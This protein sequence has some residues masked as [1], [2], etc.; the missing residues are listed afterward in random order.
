MEPKLSLPHSQQ[1][2]QDPIL[3]QTNPVHA[4]NPTSRRS[5]L[6]LS[7][8]LGLDLP[9]G[10]YPSGFPTKTPDAYLFSH[11]TC[12][13]PRQ[14]HSSWFDHTNNI[15]SGQLSSSSS[16]SSKTSVLVISILY[17]SAPRMT[18]D[19]DAMGLCVV[20]KA[21]RCVER[22]SLRQEQNIE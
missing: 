16:S 17:F 3:S 15:W 4:L 9:S 19:A 11:H 5:I 21:K 13:M 6:I 22:A 2:A 14:S 18:T 1:T 10:L 7:S 12:Y 20:A 8:H